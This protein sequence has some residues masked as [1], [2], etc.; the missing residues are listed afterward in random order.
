MFD[1]DASVGLLAGESHDEDRLYQLT[2][3]GDSDHWSWRMI[4]MSSLMVWKILLLA[5]IYP[6]SPLRWTA[7]D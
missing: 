3:E 2:C 7:P 6:L 4:V 1:D 5:R